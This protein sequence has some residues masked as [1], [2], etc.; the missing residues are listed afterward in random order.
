MNHTIDRKRA[1]KIYYAFYIGHEDDG[2][3]TIEELEATLDIYQRESDVPI[4]HAI[5][6]R[7][8]VLKRQKKDKE[9]FDRKIM[10]SLFII[11]VGGVIG[12]IFM[13]LFFP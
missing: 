4:Y 2:R 3:F 11:I 7:L 6:K 8:A 10:I 12:G 1:D 9:K 13:D 5:Q